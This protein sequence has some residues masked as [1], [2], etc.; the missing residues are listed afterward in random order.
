MFSKMDTKDNFNTMINLIQKSQQKNKIILGGEF[1][2]EDRKIELTVVGVDDLKS[3]YL[4]HDITSPVLPMVIFNS[5]SDI[6]GIVKHND[7]PSSIYLFSKN[8]KRIKTLI[9]DLESRYF[10]INN[11]T[12]PYLK[13]YCFGG[14]K[15]SGTELYGGEESVKAF[16]YKK[17]IFKNAANFDNQKFKNFDYKES[18]TRDKCFIK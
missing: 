17:I 6:N 7:K 12:M 15:N 13:K 11:I 1:N 18:K 2:E 9:N 5:F 10:F 8:K 3:P 4:T 16:S 14:V